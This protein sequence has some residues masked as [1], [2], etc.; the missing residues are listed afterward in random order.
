MSSVSSFTTL[1]IRIH[2][3]TS[4]SSVIWLTAPAARC[5]CTEDYFAP[6]LILVL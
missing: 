3:L 6:T 4:V 2:L 1:L 5:G